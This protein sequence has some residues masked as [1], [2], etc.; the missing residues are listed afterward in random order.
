MP[1]AQEEPAH[2]R[3]VLDARAL[4]QLRATLGKQADRMLPALIEQFYRDGERLLG[5][6]REAAAQGQAE[7]LRIAAHSLKSTGATFGALALAAAAREME[8]LARDGR[9]DGMAAKIA[10]AEAEFAEAKAALEAEHHEP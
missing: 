2:A 4:A 8:A 10:Q 6:A 5:Q 1:A 7:E 3:R 9:L